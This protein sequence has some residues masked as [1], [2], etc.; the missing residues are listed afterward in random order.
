MSDPTILH[1]LARETFEETGLRLT[2]FV[3]QIGSGMDIGYGMEEKKWCKLSFEIEVAEIEGQHVSCGKLGGSKEIA[4]KQD[5]EHSEVDGVDEAGGVGGQS[6]VSVTLDPAEHQAYTWV[7][8]TELRQGNY[9]FIAA[10]QKE[11]MLEAFGLRKADE[12]RSKA[13]LAGA[14]S[15]VSME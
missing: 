1:S 3:R 14:T 5:E 8:E 6:E 2:R 15:A 9:E 12:T 10:E 13:M 7:T 11:L 4:D